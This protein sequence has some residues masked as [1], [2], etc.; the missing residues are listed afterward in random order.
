MDILYA[1]GAGFA[2]AM[3]PETL[4]ATFLGALLGTLVGIL[5]GLGSPAAVALLLPLSFAMSPVSAIAM[6]AGVWY[7]SSF[8]GII[9]AVLLNMPGEGDSVIATL[10]GNQMAK[11]GRGGVALG[12]SALGGF[13]AGTF[14]LI[15][16]MYLGPS[17]AKFSL[18]FGPPEYFALML[19]GLSLILWLSGADL[20]KGLL[21]A[22]L[23]LFI[24]FVGIDLE[25]GMPRLTFGSVDLLKG[26]GFV[27]VVV[28]LFG[29]SE[30]LATLGQKTDP[31]EMQT[32]PVGWKALLPSSRD[33]WRRSMN[34]IFRGSGLGFLI[35]L[36]PGAGPTVSTFVAY[37]V[38]KKLARDPKS[39]GTG[40]IE[41]V[42][43]PEAAN[44]SA[45]IAGMVPL[46]ALGLPA[47]STAAVL[48]GGFLIH[49]L[50]PGPLLFRD[51]ADF[52][53]ALIASLYIANVLL[54]L[55]NTALIPALI[56]ILVA[57]KGILP[58]LVGV[59]VIVGA[60]SLDNSFFDVWVAIAAGFVG[61]G[62]RLVNM[63]LA[64]LVIAL[65]LGPKAEIAFGQTMSLSEG[66]LSVFITRPWTALM[67]GISLLV[68]CS[69]LVS[70]LTAARK[71]AEPSTASVTSDR[72]RS[73]SKDS[74]SHA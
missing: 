56:W 17:A 36:I 43:S 13:I 65:V 24:G 9:T 59:L 49:G 37:A 72:G 10:D 23:G 5:P 58:A 61:L 20:A 22:G 62:F 42:A 57:I 46:L 28:G 15:A 21:S 63:P 71:R 73:D 34:A 26:I 33:E 67:L 70:R 30:V 39:F 32:I 4:L 7:G 27:P 18:M 60:Y 6:L 38:E 53:W 12:I 50:V 1:L 19:M 51:H 25:S 31:D 29:L 14:A 8:G 74:Q 44:N 54:L 45:T 47:S 35:G 16:F 48:M 68:L 52:V 2:T 11:Q 69:P 64:P 66:D 55:L 3:S 40:R 41:G